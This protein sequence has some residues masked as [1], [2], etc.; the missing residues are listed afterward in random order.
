M[1]PLGGACEG[2]PAPAQH[3][4]YVVTCALEVGLLPTLEERLRMHALDDVQQVVT[5]LD[6]G[7]RRHGCWP[8]LLAHGDPRQVGQI[9]QRASRSVVNTST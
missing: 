3:V 4:S 5:V 2:H 1:E 8:A 6:L 7:L 9:C